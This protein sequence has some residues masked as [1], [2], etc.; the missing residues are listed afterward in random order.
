MPD[1]SY[2]NTRKRRT[3]KKKKKKKREE[4]EKTKR[5]EKERTLGTKWGSYITKK[6]QKVG[7]TCSAFILMTDEWQ[8][9][10]PP[11]WWFSFSQA[12]LCKETVPTNTKYVLCFHLRDAPFF[13]L[14]LHTMVST[15]ILNKDTS[16]SQV[17]LST[18]SKSKGSFPC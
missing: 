15:A 13:F 4:R 9:P 18:F 11:P 1:I 2:C 6:P 8:M 14:V 16:F 12:N 17:S 3:K 10:D 7:S 5:K